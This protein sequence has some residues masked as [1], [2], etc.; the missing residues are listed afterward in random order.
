[1]TPVSSIWVYLSASPLLGLTLT[2]AI[3]VFAE[4]LAKRLGSPAIANPVLISI[5]AIVVILEVTKTPYDRYF[6]GAKFVHFLLGPATVALAIP[7]YRNLAI[8]R[9]SALAVFVALTVG[10]LTAAVSGIAIARAL[11]AP[12]IVVRSLAPKAV[13]TPIA[14]GISEQIGGPQCPCV[15]IARAARGG[16][17]ASVSADAY[18]ESSN[19]GLCSTHGTISYNPSAI[20]S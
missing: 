18:S 11:G 5:V 9:K 15:L 8:I 20:R 7:L 4:A 10:S 19:S 12:E 3:Y 14:M 13:T 2:L 6:E 16:A 1:M 17:F